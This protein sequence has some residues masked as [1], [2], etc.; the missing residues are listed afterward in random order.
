MRSLR[1]RLFIAFVLPTAVIVIVLVVVANMAARQG[2]E[3]ELDKRLAEVAQ[4]MAVDM[5][6]GIDAAQ[7]SRLDESMHRVRGRLHNRLDEVRKATEVQRIF[8]FDDASRSLVDTDEE[9]GFGETLYRVRADRAEVERVFSQGVVARGPLFRT[10]DGSF[11]KTAYAP[12]THEGQTVAVIGVEASATYFDLL[13]RFTTVLTLLG[14]LGVAVVIGMGIWFSRL[15]VR[16]VDALVAAAGRLAKGKM[17]Q[18]LAVDDRPRWAQTEELEFLMVSFEEMRQAIVERDRQMQMM[19]AGIAHEVRNPLGGME[20]FC[21]LLREDLLADGEDPDR[22]NKVAMV[23]RIER[24][25]DY[26]ERVVEGFLDF[27]RSEELTLERIDASDF[28][29]EVFEV[30]DADAD[31]AMCHLQRDVDSG[32]E[33]TVDPGRLRRALINVI[34]NACQASQDVGEK[35]EVC[36]RKEGQRRILEV[37]D[38]GAG[39]PQDRLDELCK[40]F[41]TTRE[42]GSGLGLALTRQ[43]VEDHG[44]SL[45]IQSELGEGTTVR[46][47]LPFDD[48]VEKRGSEEE[49]DDTPAVPEGWLG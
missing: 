2:L 11:H 5:S 28:V 30:V 27:A 18:S 34:R 1:A 12:I 14:A 20:L 44:G 26:L 23:D 36:V 39:I 24:E 42:K 33:L 9:A 32:L 46:F 8:I 22:D 37:L 17:E 6:E 25:I 48:S 40:P 38:E 31:K 7:I 49:A 29:D 15:L 43:I 16:P 10:E 4:V 35:V 21:G 19:L 47:I 3:E 13:T 41:F 45:Q